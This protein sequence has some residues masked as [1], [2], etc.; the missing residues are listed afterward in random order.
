[1][2]VRHE[3]KSQLAKLLATEDLVVEHKKVETAC[4]NVHTR[5]LTLPMWEKASST[6]YDLLVA[7]E[8]GHA[9]ETPDEDWFDNYN[10]L[11]QFVNVVEDARIEKLMKRRYAG[12]SKTFFKG[13]KELADENFFCL[14]NEDISKFNLADK[15]NLYFKIGNF[16]DIRFSPKEMEIIEMIESCET[17]AD[18][19]IAAECLYKYCEEQQ[20]DKSNQINLDSHEN[21]GDD[22]ESNGEKGENSN[23]SFENKNNQ[24]EEESEDGNKQE[25]YSNQNDVKDDFSKEQKNDSGDE[26]TTVKTMKS[27][28]ESIRSLVSNNGSENVYVEIPN[29]NLNNIIISNEKIHHQCKTHWANNDPINFNWVD[30]DY[31]KFKKSAQKEV[32]YLVKEFECKK[33]A[34]SYS[35]S[36]ISR[37]GVL[38]CSKLHTYRYNEDLFK[39]VTTIPDGK[40]H[41]LIFI[42]DWSGSMAEVMLDTIKQLYNLI[43]FCKK[44]SIPFDVYAFTNDYPVVDNETGNIRECSYEKKESLIQIH[45]TFSMMNLFTSRVNGVEIEK[46]MKTIYRIAYSFRQYTHYTIPVGM[47]LSGTPLN[48]SLIS[49]H[50]IIPS[51]MKSHKVQKLQCVVL[52]DGESAPL[53]F[54]R[55]VKRSWQED[56]YIGVNYI[57][58]NSFLRDRKTGNTYAFS[59]EYTQ[60]TKTILK[61]LRDNFKETNFIGIRVIANRDASNFIRSYQVCGEEYVKTMNTWKK[62][63]SFSIQ[64]SGYH[65]YLVVSANT[66]SSDSDF[67]VDDDATKVQIKNAFVKSLRSKKTNKKILNEFMSY[68]A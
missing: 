25:E 53:R 44:C 60:F 57:D 15:A 65:T 42:L 39:K 4:F 36:S 50:K 51:F 47:D 11:P 21:K 64:N 31:E 55:V 14:E 59:S 10:I 17:F 8:C 27:L 67:D 18:T 20:S 68:V 40:N 5:V 13:Y 34:D 66:L 32:N 24:S 63:R 33:S 41:G 48:E 7:H 52:T 58:D 1:M 6:V 16:L 45:E 12:L 29:L 28:E 35:R 30:E 62:N 3:I 61:N 46:Q 37:T 9:L 23:G 54:H 2:I 22:S 19:L 49:L 38:D 43:W 56:P 26:S